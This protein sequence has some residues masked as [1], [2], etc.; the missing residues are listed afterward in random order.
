MKIGSWLAFKRRHCNFKVHK[1][2]GGKL[3]RDRC[4]ESGSKIQYFNWKYK[5]IQK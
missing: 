4:D 5:F 3:S 1:I 2:S